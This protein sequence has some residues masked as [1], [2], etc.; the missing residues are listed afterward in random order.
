MLRYFA[1]PS[2]AKRE[3]D[4]PFPALWILMLDFIRWMSKSSI[5][6]NPASGRG[7]PR[8]WRW[9][10]LHAIEISEVKSLASECSWHTVAEGKLRRPRRGGESPEVNSG[11]NA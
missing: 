9:C 3:I 6:Q 2:S 5:P 8:Q 7:L 10:R 1:G 4:P 11:R